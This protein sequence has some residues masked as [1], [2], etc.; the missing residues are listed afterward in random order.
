MPKPRD[1]D[2]PEFTKFSGKEVYPGLGAD[3][4]AWG[5]RFPQR[6]CAAQQM[7]GGDWSEDFRILGL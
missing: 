7:C 2:W 5:L 6:L 4:K 3:L 1:L